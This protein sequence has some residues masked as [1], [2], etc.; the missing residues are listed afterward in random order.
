MKTLHIHIG[1][2]K[3][4]TTAI[5]YFC[6]E[7]AGI[8]A[9]EGYCYPTFPFEYPGISK[10]HNGRFLMGVVKDKNGNRNKEQEEMNFQ[11]GMDI[12]KELFLEYDDII[13]S[14]EGIWRRSDG[15]KE[16]FWEIMVE[17]AKKANFQIHVIVYLRRQDKYF[18]SNWNQRVKRLCSN[19]TIEEFTEKVDRRRLDYYGKLE[20][21]SGVVGKENISVRRFDKD[22]FAGGSIYADFLSIFQ[23]A[24]T[25]E[26][27]VS[28][29]VR[30]IGLYGNTHEIK[31]VLNVFPWMKDEKIR[32]Y[33]TNILQEDSEISAKEY[34]CEMYS[35]EEIRELLEDYRE[36]NRKVAEEYLGEEPGADLFDDT[37]SDLPKWKKDNPYMVDDLIRVLGSV[38]LH[39][40]QHEQEFA[41]IN[42]SVWQ[43][44]HPILAAFQAL[45]R[46]VKLVK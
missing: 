12:V 24:L 32:K 15:I 7:N 35:R 3:T 46:R 29:D 6:K 5:Q 28:Q 45:K 26:Y 4:A 27:K 17:E 36:G 20:Q 37:V 40:Y 25:D 39:L 41:E 14:D 1:T 44:K 42:R 2:P 31:R 38:M 22:N 19:D 8:L 21:I 23:I 11:K 9:K 33:V 30:N 16:N 34:P 18:L 43:M 10:A 13:L